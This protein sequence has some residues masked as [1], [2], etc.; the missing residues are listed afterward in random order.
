M[1]TTKLIKFFPYGN[2]NTIALVIMFKDKILDWSSKS[3]I[4]F[5]NHGNHF[6]SNSTYNFSTRVHL[7]KLEF[8]FH[9]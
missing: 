5:T 6:S 3:N 2:W 4:V 7:R 1:K 8:E 9:T